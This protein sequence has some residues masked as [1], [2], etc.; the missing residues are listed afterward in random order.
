[1]RRLRILVLMHGDLVPPDDP[2]G[3]DPAT[4][5][6]AGD[7]RDAWAVAR[8]QAGKCC[9]ADGGF[10]W[11][12]TRRRAGQ[13]VSIVSGGGAMRLVLEVIVAAVAIAT[14]IGSAAES[15]LQSELADQWQETRAHIGE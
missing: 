13:N 7:F 6:A 1:M 15:Q 5:W 11:L 10:V 4:A 9:A 3:H 12:S 2:G 14:L 8:G